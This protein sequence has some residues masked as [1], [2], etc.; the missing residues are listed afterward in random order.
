MT[1]FIKDLI[2]IPEHVQRGDFVLR[3]SEGVNRAGE[4]LRDYVVTPELQA[5]FDNALT[6][7]SSAVHSRTSKASYLHGSF[8]SGK[9]HFMAV[10]HL[11]LQGNPAARSIPELAPV[12]QKHNDWIAGKKFLIV[13]YHMIGAH[14]MESGILGG[15]V[16]FVRRTHPQAPI[17]GVYL[18]EGLFQDARAL[19]ER[20]GDAQFFTMLSEGKGGAGGGGELEA[21]CVGA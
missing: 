5:C 2:D 4:T 9:S 6:F 16:E 19:R 17:P 10:L 12:I 15:Y 13:P 7:L 14:D 21:G 20:M 18:A 8:G 3:L 1:T 11:I